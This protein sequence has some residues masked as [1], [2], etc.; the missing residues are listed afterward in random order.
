MQE[1]G[2]LLL[3]LIP[4]FLAIILFIVIFNVWYVYYSVKR[5]TMDAFKEFEYQIKLRISL[6]GDM[7]SEIGKYAKSKNP[8]EREFKEVLK[9]VGKVSFTDIGQSVVREVDDIFKSAIKMAEKYPK[10]IS[11]E[12]FKNMR[13]EI[14]KVDE[15]M[16]AA[17]EAYF[18]S[19]GVLSGFL[20]KIP[21][22]FSKCNCCNI[23]KKEEKYESETVAPE[24]EKVSLKK[25]T[26]SVSKKIK[27][28]TPKKPET[29][30][31]NI[32]KSDK[33]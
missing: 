27:E 9:K 29:K 12:K 13:K 5:Q 21:F 16:K 2:S 3:N 14:E 28:E 26:K 25:K 11:S 33:K 10:L 18:K 17:Q 15:A 1:F 30:K 7:L 23:D 4:L 24:K 32:K 31:K 22:D 19:S 6:I 8:F 20:S